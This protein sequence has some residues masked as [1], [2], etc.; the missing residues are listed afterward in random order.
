M[1][2]NL[3]L[4]A[5]QAQAR[6]G[7]VAIRI[8]PSGSDRVAVEVGDRGPGLDSRDLEKIFAPFY[9]TKQGGAGLGLTVSRSIAE[10]HDGALTCR[11]AD[12]GG[13]VFRLE[14]GRWRG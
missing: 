11:P 3:V 2:V 7:E 9:T 6:G 8:R 14:L 10:E 5:M 13:S 4:N 1:L 12:G